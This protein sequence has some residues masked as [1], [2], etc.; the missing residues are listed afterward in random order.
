M[1]YMR[2]C[3]VDW[4]HAVNIVE[5][6]KCKIKYVL[7]DESSGRG[8]NSH[9][10]VKGRVFHC[11]YV[12]YWFLSLSRSLLGFI[13]F[14]FPSHYHPTW[15]SAHLFSIPP[16]LLFS[17][18]LPTQMCNILV[19]KINSLPSVVKSTTQPVVSWSSY[20]PQP[21]TPSNQLQSCLNVP[22]Y[23]LYIPS[24]LTFT[25]FT[26]S[27]RFAGGGYSFISLPTAVNPDP[28][29]PWPRCGG[30]VEGRVF[31]RRVKTLY[32][33]HISL[34]SLCCCTRHGTPTIL[35]CTVS[36]V[37]AGRGGGGGWEPPV[38]LCSPSLAAVGC[39][40]PFLPP[41]R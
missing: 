10:G 17:L 11:F 6:N 24:T 27:W 31:S 13:S 39:L 28:L 1:R 26:L 21:S 19:T 4:V 37:A 30:R 22:L 3:E 23:L 5:K 33:R 16:S 25:S 20:H 14:L 15:L 41:F 7:L 18:C 12:S 29:A 38:I 2:S 34:S 32:P 36:C 40:T 35:V 9:R 8:Q